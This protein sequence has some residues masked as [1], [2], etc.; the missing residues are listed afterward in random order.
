MSAGIMGA[1][2]GGGGT[3]GRVPPTFFEVGDTISN[4]PPELSS[5]SFFVDIMYFFA[6]FFYSFFGFFFFFFFFFACQKCS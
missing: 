1:N 5:K 2:P 6:C 4:V 3:G